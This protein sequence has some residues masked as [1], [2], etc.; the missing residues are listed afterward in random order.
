VAQIPEMTVASGEDAAIPA[1]GE[2]VATSSR[3]DP[4]PDPGHGGHWS[5]IAAAPRSIVAHCNTFVARQQPPG[6]TDE[7]ALL[8]AHRNGRR[9]SA[10]AVPAGRIGHWIDYVDDDSHSHEERWGVLS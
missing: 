5:R 2:A 1:K 7:Q 10:A 8:R 3:H 6:R 4:H 9:L